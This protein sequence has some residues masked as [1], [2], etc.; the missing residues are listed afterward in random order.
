ME[1]GLIL[2]LK[3]SGESNSPL[4]EICEISVNY[5]VSAGEGIIPFNS[6]SRAIECVQTPWF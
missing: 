2:Y 5:L 6:S 3:T 1:I 4:V